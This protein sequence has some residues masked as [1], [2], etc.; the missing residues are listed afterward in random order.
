MIDREE[1]YHLACRTYLATHN[2][3]R[4]FPESMRAAV[5]AILPAAPDGRGPGSASNCSLRDYFAGQ[6][7][8]VLVTAPTSK[9][10]DFKGTAEFCY[11]MSDAMLK[12]RE[13][14]K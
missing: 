2:E 13:E 14:G 3:T 1:A 4:D 12:A 11:S 9:I 6:A 5:E 10:I 8:A 7:L